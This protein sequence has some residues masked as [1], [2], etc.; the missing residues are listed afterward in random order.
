MHGIGGEEL[1]FIGFSGNCLF[2]FVSFSLSKFT[3][4]FISNTILS[5]SEETDFFKFYM[6]RE[7]DPVGYSSP[8]TRIFQFSCP[9][10]DSVLSVSDFLQGEN[11]LDVSRS[12]FSIDSGPSGSSDGAGCAKSDEGQVDQFQDPSSCKALNLDLSL[13]PMSEPDI[14][15]DLILGSPN[16]KKYEVKHFSNDRN[17]KHTNVSLLL[18]L[19]LPCANG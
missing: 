1:L 11:R 6:Q 16:T 9:G 3:Q 8:E 4:L 18:S 14:D 2:V 19:G 17:S 7:D 15:L 5:C 10:K 13:R 12:S